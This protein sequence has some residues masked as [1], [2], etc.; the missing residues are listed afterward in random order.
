[1]RSPRQ[2]FAVHTVAQACDE[3]ILFGRV[4]GHFALP[5]RPRRVQD[6]VHAGRILAL[7]PRHRALLPRW[8]IRSPIRDHGAE[9]G[10]YAGTLGWTDRDHYLAVTVPVAIGLRRHILAEHHVHPDTFRQWVRAKSLYAQEQRCG[11]TVIVRPQ[12]LA[13]LLQCSLSTVHRCQRAARELGLELVITPGR[14]LSEI[15]VYKARKVGSPQRGLSTV[16]AF[17]IPSWIE[18][19]VAHD[20]PTSGTAFDP[21]VTNVT[22]FKRRSARPKGAPLRSAPPKRR[23]G[24]A[25]ELA[26][27]LT[28]QVIF[29]HRCPPGR[30]TGQLQRFATAQ[31]HWTPERLTRAMDQ[32]NIRL[33]YTAPVEPKTAPWALLAWYLRQIDPY[34]DHPSAGRTVHPTSGSRR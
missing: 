22:T 20:T 15:E 21:I 34:A 33:G 25:W 28:Q 31:L 12:T 18:R 9:P 19:S 4:P 1:V 6:A 3:H 32:V 26:C 7:A 5:T 14:M 2:E 16:S 11:R 17:V 8:G 30:I 24:P 23:G 29:L 13:G 10:A 27:G